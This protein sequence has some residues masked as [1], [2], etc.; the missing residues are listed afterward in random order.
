VAV[1]DAT[2]AVAVAPGQEGDLAEWGITEISAS[3]AITAMTASVGINAAVNSLPGEGGVGMLPS[4]SVVPGN[5][6]ANDA[7]SLLD[8]FYRDL[9]LE[10]EKEMEQQ[11]GRITG[12]LPDGQQ[13][14]SDMAAT[15]PQAPPPLA[16]GEEI[17]P[18]PRTLGSEGTE[19]QLLPGE[20][21][22]E[23]HGETGAC[24][25]VCTRTNAHVRVYSAYCVYFMRCP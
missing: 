17:V 2:Q 4:H 24:V 20:A 8:M 7:A 9:L 10:E 13:P 25:C 1:P 6:L 22:A 19:R 15:A 16:D 14:A 18:I 3:V 12:Q 23:G 5:G 21:E 11:R